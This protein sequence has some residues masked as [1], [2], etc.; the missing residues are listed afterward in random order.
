[1]NNDQNNILENEINKSIVQ[2]S[3]DIIVLL[4][5]SGE[6]IS[7]N[8]EAIKSY[9][10]TE[11]ELLKMNIDKLNNYGHKE[12][13][14]DGV[15]FVTK[16]ARKDG[17]YFQV[18]VKPISIEIKGEKYVLYLIRDIE[19]LKDY[20]EKVKMIFNALENSGNLVLISDT[21]GNIEYVN[22][23]FELE[24]GYSKEDILEKGKNILA[25][26]LLDD[27]FD[28]MV[29]KTILSNNEWCGELCSRRKDG[30]IRCSKASIVTFTD[31]QGRIKKIILISQDISENKHFNEEITKEY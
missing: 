1:L 31:D 16:H 25:E 20:N 14:S 5:E 15:P 8:N 19:I 24:M 10:Y 28:K 26:L 30:S 18:E 23:K 27:K 9:G 12:L 7:V 17:S 4:T 29:W 21:K 13:T 3:G 2:F 11:Q 22:K 6:I